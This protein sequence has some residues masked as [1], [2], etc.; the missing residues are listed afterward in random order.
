MK[1]DV[2]PGPSRYSTVWA[3][4][5]QTGTFHIFCAEYCGTSHSGMIGTVTVMSDKDYQAW[6]SGGASEA[7]MS[8]RGATLFTQLGCVTCHKSDETGQCPKLEGVY[9]TEQQ[10]NAG[11]VLADD[12]Y[13]RESILS[14]AAKVVKGYQ[15]IM[16][17]FQ[18]IISEEQLQ[19]LLAYVKSIGAQQAAAPA[20]KSGSSAAAPAHPLIMSG[21]ASEAASA[22]TSKMTAPAAA[23]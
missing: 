8:E 5:T 22:S 4:P 14:P 1:E 21:G 7:S 18:G 2:V 23:K 13:V 16:P 10:L 17:S 3:E 19:Q 20:G 12:S 6:L 11:S 15:P 9:G